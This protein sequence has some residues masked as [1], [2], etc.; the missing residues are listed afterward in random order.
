MTTTILKKTQIIIPPHGYIQEIC[1]K[2]GCDRKTVYNALRKNARGK[3]AEKVRE[4]YRI[5]Y[6]TR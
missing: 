6:L 4:Y 5:K 2:L 1:G 3:K